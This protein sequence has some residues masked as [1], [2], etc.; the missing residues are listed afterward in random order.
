MEE[1]CGCVCSLCSLVDVS[2]RYGVVA[3]DYVTFVGDVHGLATWRENLNGWQIE[4]GVQLL[5][6]VYIPTA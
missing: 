5:I 3:L 2:V 1:G 4:I 6:K